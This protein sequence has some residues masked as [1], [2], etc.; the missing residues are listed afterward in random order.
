MNRIVGTMFFAL[1]IFALNPTSAQ[2]VCPEDGLKP[3]EQKF[4]HKLFH[5]PYRALWKSVNASILE[6]IPSSTVDEIYDRLMHHANG[7]AGP[8]FYGFKSEELNDLY[9]LMYK[10]TKCH[11]KYGSCRPTYVRRVDQAKN[12]TSPTGYMV[13]IDGEW[14]PVPED[15]T[16]HEKDVSADLW[17]K[18]TGPLQDNGINS[19]VCA[20]WQGEQLVI[21]CVL[22]PKMIG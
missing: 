9:R 19:H 11:C 10:N 1:C 18:L 17:E 7:Q 16:L 3:S 2:S 22:I 21:E 15:A 4:C 13:Q 14:Y 8:S 5:D 20:F 6:G 12:E